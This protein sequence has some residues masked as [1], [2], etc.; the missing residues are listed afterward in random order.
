M[1]QFTFRE[2]FEGEFIMEGKVTEHRWIGTHSFQIQS[3]NGVYN[4]ESKRGEQGLFGSVDSEILTITVLDPCEQA[5]VNSDNS[6]V[7]EDLI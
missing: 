1:S 4:E 3:R 6:M 7:L 5:I 2:E